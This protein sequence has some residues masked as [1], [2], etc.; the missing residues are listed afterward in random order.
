MPLEEDDGKKA[1]VEVMNKS[2]IG[3]SDQILDANSLDAVEGFNTVEE[4][5]E[6]NAVKSSTQRDT[7]T[8]SKFMVENIKGAVHGEDQAEAS[9]AVK[10]PGV[11]TTQISSREIA[12]STGGLF[13][14]SGAAMLPHP[15]K[16]LTGGEDA[17]FIT[18]NWVGV[19]DGVGQWSL[20]GINA[21]LYAQELMEGC[22]KMV[23]E[24]QGAQLIKP[25]EILIQSASKAHSSGSSTVVVAYFDGQALNVANIGDS[26]FIIIRNGCVF[27]K[28]SPMVY[29]FNF[30]LQIER[31]DDPS[32]LIEGYKIDL[33]EGDVVITATDGLF[34]NLYE[35][36][37]AS[38]VSKSLEARLKPEEIAEFL[39]TRAQE[40]GRSGSVRSPFADAAQAAGYTG[41]TGGKLDDVTVIVSVVQESSSLHSQ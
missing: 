8:S 33:D 11:E 25:E 37:I 41:Y 10:L 22:T 5:L 17:F 1:K 12:S 3:E 31:G 16:A 21:G 35:Q 32:E 19:A 36:E 23:S 13:L 40:V 39:A 27:R 20:E 9:W 28:S 26:G 4:C 14:S 7:A 18:Q 29:D 2:L 24:F 15:S 6:K 34:D 38:I 30:P